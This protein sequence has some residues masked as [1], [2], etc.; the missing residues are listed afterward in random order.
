MDYSLIPR[1]GQKAELEPS[2][3]VVVATGWKVRVRLP[4]MQDSILIRSVRSCSGAHLTYP[5]RTEDPFFSGDAAWAQ[6]A[7]VKI[8]GVMP[9]PRC[10]RGMVLR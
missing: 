4:A 3:S 7:D 6:P 5:I 10:F 8:G 1:M 2:S 9:P